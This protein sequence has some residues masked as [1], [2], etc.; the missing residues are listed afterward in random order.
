MNLKK[1]VI[2]GLMSGLAMWLVAGVWHEIVAM[3][4]Y[5]AA[6][7]DEHQGLAIIALAYHLL[8]LMMSYLYARIYPHGASWKQG[9]GFGALIGVL[10]VFPHE[11]SMAAAHGES[12]AYVFKN[13]TWHIIEQSLGGLM[14]WTMTSWLDKAG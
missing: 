6:G 1:I 11:L 8:G 7:R 3:H 9:L 14:I 12:F 13:A 10:W 5:T 2:S 4:F